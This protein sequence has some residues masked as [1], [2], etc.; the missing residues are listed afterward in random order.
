MPGDRRS[1]WGQHAEQ[2]RYDVHR[3]RWLE[4]QGYRVLR[5]W[6]NDVLAHTEAVTQAIL[7]CVVAGH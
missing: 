5:F 4:A 2:V 7:E 6:N 1:G 3:T